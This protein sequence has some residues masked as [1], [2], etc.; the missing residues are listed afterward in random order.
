VQPNYIEIARLFSSDERFTVPLFQRP[1]VW[2]R[3]DQWEPLWD[4][5]MGVLR[6]LELRQ[7]DAPVASH[8]LGTIVLEQKPTA[9][10]SL[11]RR[12]VIDGQQRLTTLQI[13]LKA[14]EHAIQS[15]LPASDGD[16]AEVWAM[17]RDKVARL[18]KNLSSG[19]ERYKVWPTN[20]D[21]APFQRVLDA[22]P[23]EGLN[24]DTSRMAEA[25][26]FFRAEAYDYL[27]SGDH[28]AATQRLVTAL[29]DY[30]KLIVLDLDKGD[31]PQA[32]FETL[33]AHGTP[34]LPAD[35][36]KNWLLWDAAKHKQDVGRLYE[37]YWRPF[38]RE[39]TY[40][41][42]TVGKGHAARARV[43]TFLQN[44]LTK[45]TVEPVSAKHIYDRFLKLSEVRSSVQS[46]GGGVAESLMTSIRT[47][48]T[49]FERIDR[50]T[51]NTRFD[52]FLDRLKSLD[53]VVFHP[54]LFE[55]MDGLSQDA[56]ALDRSA[57][58][59][60]SYLVRRM[61]CGFQTRGYGMLSIRLLRTLRENRGA[62]W[63]D[64]V[65]TQLLGLEGSD[66]WPSD[67]V[68]RREWTR[69]QFYGYFRRE[70]VLM[71]LRAI[72][73]HYQTNSS[74]TEPLM[75]FD[76][77]QVQIEHVMPQSWQEHWP[78]PDGLTPEERKACLQGIGNL[79]L[80][81]QALN[82]SMSNSAWVGK[83]QK[84][85]KRDALNK[86]AIMHMNRRLLDQ[87]KEGW[88]EQAIAERASA[89]FE[90]AKLIWPRS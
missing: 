47:D 49:R 53:V 35:L 36:M 83:D 32:I 6:R 44:W 63:S 27:R 4:D 71:I 10:G 62:D 39:H 12:E 77:T 89:L 22:K 72:E 11:T 8:F 56:E 17:E 57:A 69:R 55:L 13:M 79:T 18:T 76:W 52:V 61:T 31:E 41:R 40:W 86:H 43:D 33:N 90:D 75:T 68:F 1:Y 70:R 84:A 29:R 23:Q 38:D 66:E 51:G 9:T 25:Y 64:I 24:G 73:H 14:A 5:V 19:E 37:D 34:L 81:S 45:E 50:P 74:K 80:V 46:D 26:R 15:I 42:N 30:L 67:E 59:I 54:L 48:A 85:G 60:E 3:E 7:G 21:R 16:V 20:E 28:L 87:F 2:T 58:C 78:L 65:R 88:S 82:P